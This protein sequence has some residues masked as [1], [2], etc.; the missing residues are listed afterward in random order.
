[1]D[2]ARRDKADWI[3]KKTVLHRNK[4]EKEKEK[5]SVQKFDHKS[6][7]VLVTGISG[8]G[9]TT[10]FEQ[11]L[12]AEKARWKFIFDHQGEFQARFKMPGISNPEKLIEAAIQGGIVCF[13][14]IE[15]CNQIDPETG[16]R[17]GLDGAFRFFCD[18]VFAISEKVRGRKILV[19]DELQKLTGIRGEPTEFLTILDTGRRYQLDVFCI[20]QAPNR[21]HNAIRNQITEVY[22]FRQG[23][24]NAIA[25]LADNGFDAE[26]VRS[27]QSGLYVW[28]NLDT[29]ETR[30]GGKAF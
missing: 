14:P 20:S 16:E 25:Y 17:L 12:R 6:K 5:M 27:L 30:E 29:G 3:S 23:D 8:T 21:I 1:M 4:A 24:A 26:K 11:L 7:K 19:C 2:C 18:L 22:T 15:V 10:L 28:R 9:K 13:D